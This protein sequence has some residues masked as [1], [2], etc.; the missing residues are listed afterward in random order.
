MPLKAAKPVPVCSAITPLHG[1]ASERRVDAQQVR[2]LGPPLGSKARPG[3]ESVLG[4][5]DLERERVGVVGQ[6]DTR[7]IG[8][9]GLAHLAAPVAQ[10]HHP[11]RGAEDHWLGQREE[12]HIVGAV[13]GAGDIARE[14]EVLLLVSPTGTAV[15]W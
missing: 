5:L 15:A 7:V 4:A 6:I 14:L 2:R 12:F 11:R 8:A 3:S 10:A 9:I 1:L 13:E